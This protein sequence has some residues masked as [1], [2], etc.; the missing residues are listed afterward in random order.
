MPDLAAIGVKDDELVRKLSQR[1]GPLPPGYPPHSAEG[2][3][4]YSEWYN[5]KTCDWCE[6]ERRR[7]EASSPRR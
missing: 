1:D 7:N 6:A 4:R 5:G 3:C 2:H